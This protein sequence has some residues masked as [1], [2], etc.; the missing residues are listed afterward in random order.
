MSLVISDK[1]KFIFFHI[2]KNAGVTVST[3]LINN[4]IK[5]KLKHYITYITPY[6]WGRNNNFYIDKQ[7]NQLV[8]FN[9]H[10]TCYDFYKLFKKNEFENYFKFAIIRNPFDRA[11]SRYVY[12]KKISN[13]FKNYSFNEFLEYDIKNNLKV[14]EQ[15]SFCTFNKKDIWLDKIIKFENLDREL[16]VLYKKI[17]QKEINIPHLNKTIK[18]NYREYYDN[19]SKKII[20]KF[21]S[22]DL[23]YF[24]YEF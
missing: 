9:S 6:L 23:E 14:L 12:T 15:F 16:K 17:F 18:K 5:L 13:K 2:P 11:V 19:N 24:N 20:E 22:K 8:T 7:N 1:S 4:E 3:L 10:I 21:L